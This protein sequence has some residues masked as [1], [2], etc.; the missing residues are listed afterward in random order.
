MRAHV[1]ISGAS[2]AGPVAAY[3]LH[4]H[5]FRVTVVERAPA[6]RKTGGHAVDLFSP[7][8]RIADRMGVRE[9]VLAHATGTDRMTI[10]REGAR[11]PVTV[12]M[13][14]FM[15]AVSENHVEIMRDDLSEILYDA[16]SDDVEYVFGDEIT[17]VSDD[18]DVTFRHG[19]P[20]RF[21]L[22]IGADG[23][24]SGVRGIV[25]GPEEQYTHWL[26]GYLA[27]ASVP[28]YLN[29]TDQASNIVG[30]NRSAGMYSAKHMT[31]ARAVFLFRPATP[32]AYD[33]RDVERQKQLLR[34][35]YAGMGW[36]VPRLL[37]EM[38]RAEV[39]YFDSITQLQ[40]PHWTRGRVALAGDAGYCPGPAVGGSTSLAVVGAYT[41]AGELAIAGGDPAVAYPAY[42]AALADYVRGSRAFAAKM[43]KQ[44][45]PGSMAGAWALANGTKLL[46]VLPTGIS[47]RLTGL[48]ESGLR[49]HDAAVTR[50]YEASG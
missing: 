20:R 22:V 27:V 31:D 16:S 37:D 25:F 49:L 18:G 46:S 11:R 45:I 42:E 34:A 28:N 1:L 10:L 12:D 3:W 21:D 14:G 5:G 35:E 32:L 44:L 50:D 39:F 29:L 47:R 23:L 13:A 33:H 6:L 17:D 40:L 7:A 9:Q 19:A 41:L 38:D 26:G 36:E 8:L 2:V 30:V 24:H 48:G 15:G 4:R 43:A